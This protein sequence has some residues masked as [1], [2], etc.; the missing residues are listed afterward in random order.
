MTW[1]SFDDAFY[2]DERFF[3]VGL[4]A[5]GLYCLATGYACRHLTDGVI[6][7]ERLLVL[8]RGEVDLLDALLDVELLAPVDGGYM[9]ADFFK[10][11]ETREEVEERRRQRKLR[12]ESAARSRWPKPPA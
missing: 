2:D 6:S 3:T 5:T 7:R 8:A 1:C 11:N 9:L 12:A 10:G 4:A